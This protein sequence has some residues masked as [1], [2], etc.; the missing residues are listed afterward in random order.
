M[1][2]RIGVI[3]AGA[4]GAE[5]ARLLATAVSGVDV[6][7]ASD[8]DAARAERLRAEFGCRVHAE[9]IE[10][11]E[12]GGV[13]AVIVASPDGTH[14][15]L[16]LAC[17]DADKPV[18]CE[19]PLAPTPPACL[20]VVEAEVGLG[21]RL[22]QVGFMRRYDP[23]YRE[24]R[25]RLDSGT[26]GAPLVVHCVHRNAASPPGFGA[27][28]LVTNSAVH[29]FDVIRWLLGEEFVA[30]TTHLPRPSR[31]APAGL[32]D[33]QVLVL[34]TASGV[35]A[36]VEIFVN[37]RYG[38][39]VRCEVVG[40]TGAVS[41]H[42]VGTVTTRLDGADTRAVPSDFRDYFGAAYDAELRSWTSAA[43]GGDVH[44]PSAWDGYAASAVA[45]ACL[46]SART[47]Q[48]VPVELAPRPRL[49]G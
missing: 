8:T 7:A 15:K 40:E 22:V 38:Y 1:T 26:V 42:P 49:Y 33:P 35:L 30:A 28:M 17:L 37:A 44:G 13:D 19:K 46:R 14:E 2:L 5:H 34:R 24:L 32:A 18:L 12:D 3:G 47:G 11:I 45:D 6:V 36:D 4:M 39:D 21:R 41:L 23:G 27:E 48:T 29:E 31:Q 25:R 43:A 20:R 9:P 10:L 16:V